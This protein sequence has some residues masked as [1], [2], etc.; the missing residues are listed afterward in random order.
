MPEEL[1]PASDAARVRALYVHPKWARMGLERY[2]MQRCE[3]AA[4]EAGFG[5]LEAG[6]R[7]LLLVYILAWGGGG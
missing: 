5:R 3:E 4:R 1:D 7:L 2:V 6:P